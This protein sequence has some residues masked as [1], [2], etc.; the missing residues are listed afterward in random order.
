MRILAVLFAFF[1]FIASPISAESPSAKATEIHWQSWDES[2]FDR[3][4]AGKKLVLLDLEAVWCHWC[5][6][7]E[8]ET[9]SN[10]NVQNVI[11]KYYIPVKVDQASRPDLSARY[12]DYGWP[13]TVILSPQGQDLWKEAGFIEPKD[14]VAVLEKTAKAPASAAP[15]AKPSSTELQD[16]ASLSEEVRR[17]L[18][19]RHAG[20]RDTA[21]GGIQGVHRFLLPDPMEYALI[22]AA[23]GDTDNREWAKKTLS[24]NLKLL[25]PAWGGMYQ[26]S[27]R[28]DWDHPHFEKIMRTQADNL[29]AYS[30]GYLVYGDGAYLDAAQSI[31][32]Y[33]N[34]FLRSPDGAYYASQD[35]D[36]VQGTH[37]GD[38][39]AL[40]DK[41]RRAKGI[42]RVDTNVY[43]REN[44]WFISALMTYHG[45]TGDAAALEDGRKAAR[46]ILAHRATVEGGFRHGDNDQGGPFL[47][48]NLAMLQALVLLYQESSEREWLSHALRVGHFIKDNFLDGDLTAASPGVLSA[49]AQKN[50]KLSPVR[51]SDQNIELARAMMRLYQ[52][53][54]VI[55]FKQLAEIALRYVRQSAVALEYRTDPGILLADQEYH[56]DPL[57]LTIVAK[58]DDP[59]AAQL[60]A[61]ALRY[62]APYKRAEW[63]DKSEGPLPRSDVQYPELPRP[64]AFVCTD[65]RCSLPIFEPEK[66]AATIELFSK[67]DKSL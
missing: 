19:A 39:F 22:E 43:S 57:H 24:S 51:V 13:A 35:A 61:A 56:S 27:T 42:P 14:F 67:K 7:M 55:E 46:W 32:R 53:S 36:L 50:A 62:F 16:M 26:Y 59:K 58:K 10:Q 5:H 29:A 11:A 49:K 48:D 3:A 15:A 31:R 45:A 52:Y 38:Y 9:Y 30:R 18:L 41:E 47:A 63:W 34:E 20:T 8:Q 66:I 4:A 28:S 64:A 40:G 1:S 12:Q 60:F 65:K 17:E 23:K 25:D 6:V 2:L 33:V 54:G 21:Q 44:G 37:S